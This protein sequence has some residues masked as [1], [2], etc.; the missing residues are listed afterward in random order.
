MIKFCSYIEIKEFWRYSN[1]TCSATPLEGLDTID[2][3]GKILEYSSLAFI[4]YGETDDNLEM[5]E[6]G[7]IRRL[8]G[9]KWATYGKVLKLYFSAVI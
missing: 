5:L 7:V 1:I 4:V 2:T 9:D 6:I 3:D 8:L